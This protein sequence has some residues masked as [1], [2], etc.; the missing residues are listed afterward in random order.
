MKAK[1]AWH[2]LLFRL[3]TTTQD[4]KKVQLCFEKETEQDIIL[5]TLISSWGISRPIDQQLKERL[6][7]SWRSVWSAAEK[8]WSAAEK[9][10]SAAGK[11]SLKVRRRF[12]HLVTHQEVRNHVGNLSI[13][14]DVYLLN[15][16]GYV[17]K[18]AARSEDT[19]KYTRKKN[20]IYWIQALS[21]SFENIF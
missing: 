18:D 17:Y 7:S 14:N 10:W 8:L 4:T 3:C 1:L 19:I 20:I 16:R 2:Q 21:E 11:R 15:L 6:I 9:L 13:K 12:G 5:M